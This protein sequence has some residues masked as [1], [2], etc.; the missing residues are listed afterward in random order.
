MKKQF[1]MLSLFS[2]IFLS[3]APTAF[4]QEHEVA[5]LIGRLK[6]TDKG[7]QSLEPIKAAFDGSAA[8]QI[9]YARRIVEGGAVS[10]H[11]EILGLG[12][13]RSG[14]KSSNVFLPRS[15]SSFFL[16]PGLK[17]KLFPGGGL[18]PYIVGGA[19]YGRYNESDELINGLP[20][21][22]NRGTN[23]F[24]FNYGGGVDLNVL[25]VVALRG[26]IRDF[27]TGTPEFNVR[28]IDERHHN[29][30]VAVGVVLRW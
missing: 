20:N 18:S 23:T 19:G 17:L 7:L 5:F 21:A 3:Y 12:A 8:Y 10:V 9:N 15:Y 27:I 4:S 29:V 14:I 24:A 11:W 1:L 30:W 13:P 26:E 25:G 28:L 22:G 2:F 16:T 6:P